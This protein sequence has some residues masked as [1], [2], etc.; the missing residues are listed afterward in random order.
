MRNA[1]AAVAAVVRPR[2]ERRDAEGRLESCWIGSITHLVRA[3]LPQRGVLKHISFRVL[4]RFPPINH[5]RGTG[6]ATAKRPTCDSALGPGSIAYFR[7][8]QSCERSRSLLAYLYAAV[9]QR[10]RGEVTRR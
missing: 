4:R 2:K 6:G 9:R 5:C 8:G 7:G 10:T 1:N 3:I